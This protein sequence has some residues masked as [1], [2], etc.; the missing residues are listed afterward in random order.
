MLVPKHMVG[1]IIGRAG[2][3]IK[4]IREESGARIDVSRKCLAD[5]FEL[6]I[7]F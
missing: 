2:C 1:R 5:L 7:P 6:Q 3:K 4:E